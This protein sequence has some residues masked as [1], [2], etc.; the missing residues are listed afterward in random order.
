MTNFYTV[1]RAR[2][3]GSYLTAQPQANQ[4]YLLLFTEATDGLIYLSTHA[5]DL[6]DQ[7]GTETISESQLNA[8][9]Q[10]WGF[11]GFA[12]VKDPMLPTVEFLI[13]KG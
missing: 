13:R 1:L 7:F 11:H 6:R 4:R 12:L 9:M 3:D 8:L 2:A 10:R 5:P